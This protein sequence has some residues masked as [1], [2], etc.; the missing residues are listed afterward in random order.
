MIKTPEPA[1]LRWRSGRKWRHFPED[2]LPAWIADMDFEPAPPI[3]ATLSEAVLLGDFGYGPP[4][5]RSGIPEAFA[6]WAKRR[7]D[8]DC[9][10]ADVLLMPDVVG[11]IGN[12]IEALTEPGD[13]ILVQTPAYPPLLSSV[14][15]AGRTLVEHAMSAGGQTDLDALEREIAGRSVRLMLF[16]HP[17][18]PTGHVFTMAELKRLADIADRHGVIIISDEVHADLT[19]AGH[20]HF[21][22]APLLPERTVTLNAASKAFNI[23]GL[24]TAIC[25]APPSLRNKLTA[26]PSTRWSAFSTMGVRATLAAWSDAG[27]AWLMGCIDH[28]TGQREHL[29]RRLAEDFPDID[30]VRP[31]AGYLAWL[32]CRALDIGDPTAFF[33]ERAR[34]AL[35]PGREFGAPGQGFARLNF[36]TSFEILDEILDRMANALAAR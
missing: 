29:V 23:A 30:F 1:R 11:G 27:E 2:V 8:W 4:A 7:W 28:L 14:R 22:F 26:L 36:A 21:P 5:A 15:A 24:R 3:A 33:L 10:P 9:D 34:V 35:S 31:Q 13:A 17:H 20:W 6:G 12:C 32:D 25:V 18:N 16:C 19:Y